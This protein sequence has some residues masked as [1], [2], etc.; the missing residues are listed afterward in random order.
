[1]RK[2]SRDETIFESGIRH[3]FGKLIGSVRAHVINH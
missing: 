1:M 2:N 3:P